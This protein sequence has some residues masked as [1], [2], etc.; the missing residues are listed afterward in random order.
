MYILNII[1][2]HTIKGLITDTI[3]DELNKREG[4]C[5]NSFNDLITRL[6]DK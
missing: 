5:K 2:K 1:D 3:K 4:K 6:Q